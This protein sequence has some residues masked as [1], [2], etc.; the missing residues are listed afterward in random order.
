MFRFR[1][2]KKVLS[3]V[4]K[5]FQS[6]KKYL[7]KYENKYKVVEEKKQKEEEEEVNYER[8][9]EKELNKKNKWYLYS[10]LCFISLYLF[11]KH[12]KE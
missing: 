2:K 10:F 11:K 5:R 3:E 4:L 6:K 7:E 8:I 1:P 9:V 12:Q